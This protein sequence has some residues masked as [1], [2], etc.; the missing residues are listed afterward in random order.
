MSGDDKQGKSG[1]GIWGPGGASIDTKNNDVFI[2]TGNADASTGQKQNAD[3]GEQVIELSPKLNK[4]IANNYPTNILRVKR[5]TTSILARPRC[6]SS[7]RVAPRSS[8]RSTSRACSALRPWIDQRGHT[9]YRDVGSNG[10][11][12]FH[13]RTGIRPVTNYVYVGLPVNEG[14][15]QP[16]MAAFSIASNCTLNTTPVW[17]QNFGPAGS[18]GTTSRRSPISIA[19]GVVYISN[20]TGDTEYAFDAATGAQLWKLSLPSAGDQGTLIANGMV[21]SAP[22]MARSRP[23]HYQRRRKSYGRR[24]FNVPHPSEPMCRFLMA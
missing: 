8:R 9:V 16:G 6:F 12:S 17:S 1:G 20:F 2:A 24:P 5:L 3:Y 14:I 7:H 19:N 13:W 18:A 22:T 4:I 11:R 10:S 21:Y 15:Y 23:G